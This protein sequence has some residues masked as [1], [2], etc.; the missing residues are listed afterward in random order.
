MDERLQIIFTRRSIRQYTSHETQ[1]P[2]FVPFAHIRVIRVHAFV[3][4]QASGRVP[5]WLA[6]TPARFQ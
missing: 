1:D 6:M 5:V 3:R 4:G 2:P